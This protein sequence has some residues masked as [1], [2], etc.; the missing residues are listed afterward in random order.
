M[1]GLDKTQAWWSLRGQRQQDIVNSYVPAV[2]H[3]REHAKE[4]AHFN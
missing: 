4:V 1:G 2:N 3:D